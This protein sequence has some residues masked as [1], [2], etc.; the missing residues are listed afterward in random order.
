[1]TTDAGSR[2][3]MSGAKLAGCMGRLSQLV[4][5]RSTLNRTSRSAL[6]QGWHSDLSVRRR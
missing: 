5:Q 1:M 3:Q 4:G 6:W 2:R